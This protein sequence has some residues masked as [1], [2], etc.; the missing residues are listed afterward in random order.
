M[1]SHHWKA[2]QRVFINKLIHPRQRFH[3]DVR[4][5][6]AIHS[7]GYGAFD[8][9]GAVGGEFV[10]VEMEVGVGEQESNDKC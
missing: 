9:Q 1:K 6:K 3:I 7:G 4:Q 5:Q 10:G 8:E 2:V